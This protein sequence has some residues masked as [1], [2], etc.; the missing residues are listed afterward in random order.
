MK[1]P[2]FSIIAFLILLLISN[3]AFA[4]K[5]EGVQQE[6]QLSN[7]HSIQ[8]LGA[9]NVY[10]SQGSEFQVVVEASERLLNYVNTSVKGG[11]LYIN[12]DKIKHI[13]KHEYHKVFVTMPSIKAIEVK[14]AADMFTENMI[15]ASDL[16]VKVTGAGDLHLETQ[17]E[18][19]DCVVQGA[20]DVFLSGKTHKLI[21]DV[22][23]AGDLKAYKMQV[24]DAEVK[25]HGS[26]DVYVH[27]EQRMSAEVLGSGD[28]HYKG[29]PNIHHLQVRG[30]G[31]IHH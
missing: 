21:T 1:K 29:E 22:G 17:C 2:I 5:K 4:Q 13:K 9:C 25:V 30:S 3:L 18:S 6:R 15:Q 16:S 28:L 26:G 11:V 7:F 31:D 8:A 19:L 14:G 20:G 24:N 12:T 23:G 10:L 27:V